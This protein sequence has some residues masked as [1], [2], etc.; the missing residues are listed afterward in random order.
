MIL[1]R[2]N[3]GTGERWF[4]V[5][6]EHPRTSVHAAP[7]RELARK[8]A[9]KPYLICGDCSA[10]RRAA[11][12]YKRLLQHNRPATLAISSAW[13][14]LASVNQRLALWVKQ[15]VAVDYTA[16]DSPYEDAAAMFTDIGRGRVVISRA[17]NDHPLWTP[18]QNMEFR[19]VHDVIG[20]FGSKGGFDFTG[21]RAACRAHAKHL[22]SAA[23]EAL[24]TECIG[25][26]AAA[27]EFGGYLEQAV[28][29]LESRTESWLRTA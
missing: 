15:R 7:S 3:I 21:E 1:D 11:N 5:C 16:G 19:L 14:E 28:G 24:Y 29:F 13:R 6:D 12:A 23:R 22:N 2:P 20:H 25:Q 18:E 10:R 4:A 8:L 26:T 27:I 17:N 9:A